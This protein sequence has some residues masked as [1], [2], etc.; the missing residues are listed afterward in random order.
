MHLPSTCKIN[1][2]F[3][4]QPSVSKFFALLMKSSR[5]MRN[6]A[7]AALAIAQDIYKEDHFRVIIEKYGASVK[8][9]PK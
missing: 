4:L 2:H 6:F 9:K 8:I 5:I 3:M 7:P 1:K